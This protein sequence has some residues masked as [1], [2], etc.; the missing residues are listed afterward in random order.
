MAAV[1]SATTAPSLNKAVELA[2]STSAPPEK[3]IRK[4][5][6]GGSASEL[7]YLDIPVLDL[8]LLNF[9]T[10]EAEEELKKLRLGFSSC[11]YFQAINHWIDT[12]AEP[13]IFSSA[14]T[15]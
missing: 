14:G 9:S 6:L 1:A 13:R 10:P 3:Y 12:G 15:I 11:G 2:I 8:S 5:G 7:P 4:E